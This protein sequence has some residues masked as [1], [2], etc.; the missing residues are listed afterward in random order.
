MVVGRSE[1]FV[2]VVVM[3]RNYFDE[4]INFLGTDTDLF[5]DDFNLAA[6]ELT[7]VNVFGCSFCEKTYKTNGGLNRHVNMKHTDPV[8][9]SL[10]CSTLLNLILKTIQS[11]S[12]CMPFTRAKV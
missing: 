2:V 6:E 1:F 3:A 10:D 12:K 7:V 4:I 9:D 5:D 8:D 11:L